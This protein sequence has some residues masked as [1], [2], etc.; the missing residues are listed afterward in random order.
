MST[1]TTVFPASSGEMLRSL[2]SLLKE[3][4]KLVLGRRA[5]ALE[6]YTLIVDEQ[7]PRLHASVVSHINDTAP[8]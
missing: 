6:A 7:D 3:R 2:Q 8:A 1:P 5:K 4:F